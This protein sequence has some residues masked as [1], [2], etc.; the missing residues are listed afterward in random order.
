MHEHVALNRLIKPVSNVEYKCI[1]FIRVKVSVFDFA[2]RPTY[3][4]NK[5]DQCTMRAI[6]CTH[7]SKIKHS[8]LKQGIIFWNAAGQNYIEA[9]L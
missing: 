7:V 9:S 3:S 6:L 8:N 5:I 1:V 4:A 2:T